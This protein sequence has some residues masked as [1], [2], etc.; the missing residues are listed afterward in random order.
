MPYVIN[1]DNGYV[2]RTCKYGPFY[3]SIVYTRDIKEARLFTR[4]S[5]AKNSADV[6]NLRH[7]MYEFERKKNPI[8][9]NAIAEEQ[10]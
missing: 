6:V 1:T 7:S 3:G 2:K 8:Y 5:D 9:P 4:F 10:V